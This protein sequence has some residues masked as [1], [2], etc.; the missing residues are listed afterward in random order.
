[1]AR[2][3]NV[4]IFGTQK[5]LQRPRRDEG[6]DKIFRVMPGVAADAPVVVEP[7]REVE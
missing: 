7:W 1:M 3:P 5:K 6:F 2:V 4:A